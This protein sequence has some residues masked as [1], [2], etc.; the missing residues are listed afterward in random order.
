MTNINQLTD[1]EEALNQLPGK[2]KI[3][4]VDLNLDIVRLQNPKIQKVADF[5]AS[6]GL[7]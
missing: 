2:Y 5:L 7:V 1:L 6:F 4:I 3:V